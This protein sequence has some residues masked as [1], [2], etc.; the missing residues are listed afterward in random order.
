MLKKKIINYFAEFFSM[1]K[2]G[3]LDK[4]K[5]NQLNVLFFYFNIDEKFI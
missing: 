2:G 5:K 3:P 4:L 1:P